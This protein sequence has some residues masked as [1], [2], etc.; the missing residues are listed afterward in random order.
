MSKRDRKE[1]DPAPDA[2]TPGEE[3]DENEERKAGVTCTG[4]ITTNQGDQMILWHSPF[5][6]ELGDHLT[7]HLGECEIVMHAPLLG[8][9]V[10][11]FAPN[12]TRDAWALVTMGLSGFVMPFPPEADEEDQP[13]LEPLRRAELLMYVEPSWHPNESQWPVHVLRDIAAYIVGNERFVSRTHG[14]A[15]F[16]AVG[17]PYVEGGNLCFAVVS[18]EVHETE[19]FYE[20]VG[21]NPHTGEECAVQLLNVVGLTAEEYAV[22]AAKRYDGIAPWI[23]WGSDIDLVWRNNRPTCAFAPK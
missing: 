23:R 8:M 5:E 2:A 4:L 9:H 6:E 15:N 13:D 18:D 19:D 16:A 10:Y 12:P 1:D 22:K 17:E 11:T 14:L 3:E 7:E 20:F 21:V